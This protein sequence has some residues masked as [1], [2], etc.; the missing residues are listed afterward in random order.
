[1]KLKYLLA[2]ILCFCAGNVRAELQIDVNGAMRDPLPIAFPEMIHEGFWIGQYAKRIRNVVIADLERSGLFRIIPENSYIQELTS[3]NQ[4]PNFTD[5]KAINAHALVQSA[6]TQT[7]EQHLKVEFRLWDVFSQSQLKGQSFTTTKDNWRRVAHV[8]ADAIYER[9]TGEKGYFDTRIVYVSETGPAT[10]RIKR[11][12]IMDQ[13]GENHKFLTSGVAMAL[14]PR[15]SPNLQ[16]ITYMSYSGTSPK[17]YILD[18]ETGRQELLGNFPGMTFAPRFSPDSK[19]VLLS[20]ASGGNTEIYEMDLQNRT[21]RQLTKHP[22]IDTSPSYSP[23]GSQIVFNSDRG[24]NQQLYVMNADGSDVRRISFG[25]GRYATPVWS[26]RGD[27]I[28]FTK[29]ANGRFYIGVMFPDGS[30]ERVLAE[31][32]LVEGPTWSP[33]GRVLMYF[34]QEKGDR[35]G[36]A[37]VKLY[38]IDLTGYN[39][40]LIVTPADASDPAWSPL[41]P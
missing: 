31:G 25:A 35:R 37:P 27:Y 10:R 17:V 12:A 29:M 36:N 32:Y 28:A 21:S 20:F 11:L 14:T 9:L 24:G 41:L 8:I 26:P 38:S 30:G 34:R 7:D 16:K 19:K 40:R 33:N 18:L 15:F 5:W 1:M 22:A 3:I 2:L 13:D 6:V 39:E 23:D 4:E